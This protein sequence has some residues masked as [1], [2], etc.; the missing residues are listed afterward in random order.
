[1]KDKT[2]LIQ[3][4]QNDEI[5]GEFYTMFYNQLNEWQRG[6]LN[7]MIYV[8]YVAGITGQIEQQ[9]EDVKELFEKEI[10]LT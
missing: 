7:Q 5:H 1:M 8:G 10:E 9:L 3:T 4:I 6:A 2:E